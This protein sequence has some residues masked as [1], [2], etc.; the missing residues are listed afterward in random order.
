MEKPEKEEYKLRVTICNSKPIELVDLT[1]SLLSMADEYRR[2]LISES[3]PCAAEEIK[4][5]IKD[6]KSGSIITELFA[7]APLILPMVQYGNTLFDFVKNF[8]AATDY[9]LGRDSK[10]PEITTTRLE[11]L[12][13]IFEPIVKDESAQFNIQNVFNG[14]V[15]LTIN[16]NS[17]EANTVQNK[18]RREREQLKEPTQGIKNQ[19]LMYWYQ[20][21]KDTKSDRGDRAIIEGISHA[22]VKVIMDECIKKDLIGG[23][24]NIFKMGYIVDVEVQTI[25]GKLAIY[26][27]LKV[28]ESIKLDDKQLPMFDG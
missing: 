24:D 3:G 22:P 11:N 16:Y 14:E 1:S 2:F 23:S 8:K 9:F 17:L 15:K 4:L 5:Y 10:K 13:N 12:N 20:A 7:A 18:I 19:V 28:H 26:K 27:I 6:I 25:K 21:R